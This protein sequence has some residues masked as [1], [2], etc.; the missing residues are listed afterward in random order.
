M[1]NTNYLPGVL[2][3]VEETEA[4]SL[5]SAC[6]ECYWTCQEANMCE[7]YTRKRFDAYAHRK[8]A[9]LMLGMQLL[10]VPLVLCKGSGTMVFLPGMCGL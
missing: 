1:D 2:S 7:V 8:V 10:H 4:W 3:V 9:Y 5:A 6:T